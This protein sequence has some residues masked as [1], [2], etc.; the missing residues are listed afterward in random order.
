MIRAHGAR[1][2]RVVGVLLTGIAVGCLGAGP[3]RAQQWSFEEVVANLKV[4]DP[5]V[6]MEALRLL[7]QAGY[8]EGAAAVAPLLTD[9]VPEIQQLAIETVVSL[10][11]VDEAYVI[12]FGQAAVKQKGASLPLL[13]FAVGRG[14]TIANT[15]PPGVVRALASG[16][17]SAV[18]NT[19]FDA[20][21]A[22]G[23]LGPPLIRQGQ[24]PEGR[25]TFERLINLSRD[26]NPGI[27]LAA[28]HV[29]GRLMGAALDNPSVN[30]DILALRGDLGDQ[31]ISGMNDSDPLIKL[32]A[33]AALGELRHDRAIQALTDALAYYKRDALGVAAL[34]ALAHIAHPSSL[35]LFS[36][37]LDAKDDHGR[38][39]AVE[40]VAR[41]GDTTAL[42]NLLVRTTREQSRLLLQAVAFA[43]AK[44]GDFSQIARVVEGLRDAE[45]SAYAF[46]YLVELGPPLAPSL[47]GAAS[48]KDPRVRAGVAEVLGIIGSQASLPVLDSLS[49]DKDN[50]VAAAARRSQRRL[51]PRAPAQPRVP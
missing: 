27:R 25:Q 4:G 3:A 21:Y 50:A 43:R 48:D 1:A 16:L 14:V 47:A 36:A 44:Q 46:A 34:D 42:S 10:Y 6:R 11:L 5:K 23:V 40:G 9:P 18:P 2:R 51:V 12:E 33:M 13:A 8:L 17:A 38:Q 20:A 22:I 29:I 15:P 45:T 35:T 26:P 39:A 28:T 24:F 32:A 19:T 30:A 49:N 41:S 7:R 37:L 31:L